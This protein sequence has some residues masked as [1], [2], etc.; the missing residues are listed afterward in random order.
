MKTILDPANGEKGESVNRSVFTWD[1]WEPFVKFLIIASGI[2]ILFAAFQN[3]LFL[4]WD[5]HELLRIKYPILKWLF[6]F[7]S[8][9]F[10]VS[11]LVRT[12]LW[13][14]YR[15]FDSG[16]VDAWPEVTVVVPAY[17]EGETV[18]TTICSIA[19]CD[20][21][22][23][24]LTI[25]AIDDGSKD[26]TYDYM[27]RAKAKYPEKVKLIRFEKNSGKRQG[28]FRGFQEARTPFFITI[29]SD[30]R[31]EPNAIKEL[32]TPLILDSRIAAVTGKIG[33]WN[34]NAN[35]FTRMLKVNFAMA[36]DFTR[37]IQSTYFTV[38]CTSGAFSAY[39]SS[40]LGTVIDQWLNQTFFNRRCTYGEDRSLANHI[41]R[42]GYGTAFQRTAVAFTM[43]PE[44]LFNVLKMMTRWARS[45]IRESIVF[46]T[47]MFN[48][49]R[50]GNYLLPFLEF[51]FTTILVVLHLAIF[52]YFLFSGFV[53]TTYVVQTVAYTTLFGFFYMLYY[54][55]IEGKKDFPY[56]IAFSIFSSIFMIWI[57]TVAGFTLNRKGWSTR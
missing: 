37:A 1:T 47:L 36:F 7:N 19:D 13:F 17:N 9:A 40:V 48:R 22:E 23:D 35:I 45:N 34:S 12:F 38:F 25:I 54:I 56:V 42:I 30:T 49:N 52:Y 20:Y 41:L 21:P 55:R 29:D 15:S 51:F 43:V 53:N 2:G 14:R 28:I 5:F 46:S 8:I 11:L 32:L 27:C 57:F 50:K 18:Y 6:L 4:N 24:R 31:L 26:D 39:R 33:I 3:N 44:N 10:L 16:K